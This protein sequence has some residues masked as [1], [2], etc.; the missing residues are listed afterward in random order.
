MVSPARVDEAICLRAVRICMYRT[1]LFICRSVIT[2][3]MCTHGELL[4]QMDAENWVPSLSDKLSCIMSEKQASWGQ[5]YYWVFDY[6]LHP[7]DASQYNI[8]CKDPTLRLP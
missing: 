6:V 4:P 7:A 3:K 2:A 8:H 1:G 5:K